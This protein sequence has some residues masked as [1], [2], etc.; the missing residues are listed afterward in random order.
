MECALPPIPALAP[1]ASVAVVA[2]GGLAL[3]HWLDPTRRVTWGGLSREPPFAVPDFALRDDEGQLLSRGDL[4]GDAGVP[5]FV[6][7]QCGDA[8]TVLARR[9]R[10]VARRVPAA[11][12]RFVS[13]SVDD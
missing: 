13:F 3:G 6:F 12:V 8:C 2:A 1:P 5:D 4:V 7:L 11:D 9:V 10:D